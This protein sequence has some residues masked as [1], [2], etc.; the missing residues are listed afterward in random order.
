LGVSE[1]RYP[2]NEI[3]RKA[4][5]QAEITISQEEIVKKSLPG[6]DSGGNPL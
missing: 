1:A 4:S 5:N 6:L 3:P 2:Q